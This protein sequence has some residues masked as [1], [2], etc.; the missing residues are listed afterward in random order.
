M[1][2]FPFLVEIA[3]P[4]GGAKFALFVVKR[5]PIIK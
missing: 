1:W 3:P 5:K 4:A 2:A